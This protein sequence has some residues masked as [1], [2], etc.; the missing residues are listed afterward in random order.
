MT[1]KQK[2]IAQYQELV[3]NFYGEE[4][5]KQSKY[6]TYILGGNTA[7]ELEYMIEMLSN[8]IAQAEH[9]AKI[10]AYYATEEGAKL[11]A[12]LEEAIEDKRRQYENLITRT[13]VNLRSRLE[14]KCG[15]NWTLKLSHGVNRAAIETGLKND[16]E[17][18]KYS[19]FKFGHS[20]NIY[21]DRRWEGDEYK[22]EVNYG[23]LGTFT[24]ETDTARVEYLL[25]LGQIVADKEFLEIIKNTIIEMI[26]KCNELGNATGDYERKLKNPFR[27]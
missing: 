15:K 17:D 1:K 13:E 12:E 24:P 22:L 18:R 14:D 7:K 23:T 3:K 27:S 21:V 6:S 11:K 26:A 10:E 25:G 9:K 19:T 5:L 16:D 20:F 4:Y 2:L 8:K